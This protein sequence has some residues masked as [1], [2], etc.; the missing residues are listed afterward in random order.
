M[1]VQL[2]PR[3]RHV[4]EVSYLIE[5]KNTDTAAMLDT[6][7]PRETTVRFI[8][9]APSLLLGVL[10]PRRTLGVKKSA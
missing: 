6:T 4:S 3:D 10:Y 7:K 8:G 1:A 9:L 5:D 2:M